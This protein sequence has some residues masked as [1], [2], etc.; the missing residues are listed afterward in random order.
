M[1]RTPVSVGDGQ[2]DGEASIVPKGMRRG[3]NTS[4]CYTIPEIPQDGFT[5]LR[6]AKQ[7]WVHETACKLDRLSFA[8]F[9]IR[10]SIHD[11]VQVDFIDGDKD[12]FKVTQWETAVIRDDH[13]QRID[14]RT[15]GFGRCP[16]KN[17]GER[18]DAGA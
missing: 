2:G 3:Q 16:A 10:T 7:S 15:L 9:L 12:D 17:A 5:C 11:W 8:G 18:V 6:R 13:L 14:A 1:P 4:G